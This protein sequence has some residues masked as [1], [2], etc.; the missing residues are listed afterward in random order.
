MF[1]KIFEKMLYGFGFGTGMGFS[2]LIL[3]RNN[4]FQKQLELD[5]IKSSQYDGNINQIKCS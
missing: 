3:P 4:F 5:N 1:I 2:F